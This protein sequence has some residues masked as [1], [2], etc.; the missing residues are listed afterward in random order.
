VLLIRHRLLRDVNIY[1]L[2]LNNPCRHFYLCT[3]STVGCRSEFFRFSK[4]IWS[5]LG[6]S[7][8]APTD[9]DLFFLPLAELF[10]L[11]IL[12]LLTADIRKFQ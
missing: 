9:P 12:V 6:I 5:S 10:R 7:Q 4:H 8:T 3:D 11:P 1:T 2:Y